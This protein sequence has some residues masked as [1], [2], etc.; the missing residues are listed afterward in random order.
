M[1]LLVDFLKSP[2]RSCLTSHHEIL[3]H[4]I[5]SHSFHNSGGKETALPTLAETRLLRKSK[6]NETAFELRPLR[7]R[8][9]TPAATRRLAITGLGITGLQSPHL[10]VREVQ[11]QKDGSETPV[12]RRE[13]WNFSSN[14]TDP[15]VL[16]RNS[17]LLTLTRLQKLRQPQNSSRN[18]IG[19]E[20]APEF[21]TGGSE[22]VSGTPTATRLL[23]QLEPKK[24]VPKLNSTA[25]RLVGY[26]VAEGLRQKH[27][28]PENQLRCQGSCS[29]TQEEARLERN[30]GG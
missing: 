27:D 17:T 18:S 3:S 4:N 2:I 6:K 30:S 5:Q 15:N 14:K 7:D 26:E 24:T 21:N 28:C 10:T 11:R 1:P 19:K 13:R 25:T 12:S 20:I 22:D 9:G 8:S 16:L 29:R 23:R